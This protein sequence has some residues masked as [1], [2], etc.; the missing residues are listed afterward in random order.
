[1]AKKKRSDRIEGGFHA[2][3]EG[4]IDGIKRIERSYEELKKY[5]DP[6]VRMPLRGVF[7]TYE[8]AHN[9]LYD[10]TPPPGQAPPLY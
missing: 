7:D 6:A 9:W 10:I 4:G 1:M 3:K 5:F 2:L 8:D